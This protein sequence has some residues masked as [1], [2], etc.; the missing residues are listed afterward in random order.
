MKNWGLLFGAC[1]MSAVLS[2]AGYRYFLPPVKE[3]I[4]RESAPAMY[5]N[6]SSDDPLNVHSRS[7]LSSSP[8]NFIIS[9]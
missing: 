4:I 8:T 3:V 6:Y 7:F 1:L 2:I 9:F 5:T